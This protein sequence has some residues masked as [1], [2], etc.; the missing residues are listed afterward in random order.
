M[1]LG[2]RIYKTTD[3]GT[4]WSVVVALVSASIMEI[5]FTD[6]GHGWACCADG[7]VLRFN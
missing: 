5:H 7:D 6:A 3:A 4:T 1:S 2:T